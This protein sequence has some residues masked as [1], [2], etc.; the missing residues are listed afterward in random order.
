MKPI[1]CH[2]GSWSIYSYHFFIVLGI[3]LGLVFFY[4]YSK[5]SGISQVA[6][7]DISLISIISAYV[8][9]RLF[10]ILFVMPGFY[11]S[12]PLEML[13]F[14]KG[15]FVIYGAI[16]VPPIFV[17]LYAKKNGLVLSRITDALAPSFSIGYGLGRVACLMQ[18]CCYGKP[19]DLPWGITF[20]EGA[21][22]GMTPA[23]IPLHPTQ[24]YLVL[25]G[26][27][28]FFV[29]DFLFRRKKFDGEITLWFFIMYPITRIVIEYY[30]S[31]F[32][33]DLFEP[34]LSTSQ[35]ISLIVVIIAIGILIKNHVK[36]NS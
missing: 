23:N 18:G 28:I 17:Y 19:T 15:G 7:T 34:Y 36:H 6:F 30:R 2:I 3:F 1:L 21:N 8:G 12:H 25:Q 22:A 33:G 14:W 35:L 13:Y 24:V 32:R 9:A 29:L 16:L 5:K 11:F 4:R 20:P 10:Q 27:V 31:D 26:L